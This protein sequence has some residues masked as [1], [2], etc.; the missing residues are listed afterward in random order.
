M[1]TSTFTILWCTG[2]I[3]VK[4]LRNPLLCD[5]FFM[6]VK[7]I[8]WLLNSF[9]SLMT[10]EKFCVPLTGTQNF[11]LCTGSLLAFTPSRTAYD[12]KIWRLSPFPPFGSFGLIFLQLFHSMVRILSSLSGYD[13]T[14]YHD[15]VVDKNNTE[16]HSLCATLSTLY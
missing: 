2:N 11:S 8:T 9:R 10:L 16:G 5:I 7:D 4:A 14:H 13:L 15:Q 3:Y 12:T 6:S 1:S